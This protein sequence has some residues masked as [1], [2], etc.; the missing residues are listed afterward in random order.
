MQIHSFVVSVVMAVLFVLAVG[1]GLSY[2][3]GR[4]S[5]YLMPHENRE[6]VKRRRVQGK[7]EG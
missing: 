3:E 5:R 1:Y 6:W 2:L 7:L 4:R